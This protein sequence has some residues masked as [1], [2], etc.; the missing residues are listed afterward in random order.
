MLIQT[1]V[2][3]SLVKCSNIKVGNGYL[4][5]D[6]EVWFY[7]FLCDFGYVIY[8]SVCLSYFVYKVQLSTFSPV[9]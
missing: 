8:F 9:S 5:D 7:H 6:F 4:T 3:G 1:K 2:R